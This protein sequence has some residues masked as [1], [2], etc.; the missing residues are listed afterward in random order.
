MSLNFVNK[1][2]KEFPQL[3]HQQPISAD[4]RSTVRLFNQPLW[5]TLGGDR[6]D[7]VTVAQRIDGELEWPEI[8]PLAQ[9]YAG[10][11]FGHFNPYLGDG[12]GLLLG[13]VRA[14]SGNYYDLHLKGAGP[15]PY[16]RGGDGRAVLRS[17]IREY[18]ASEAFAALGIPTTRA[19]MLTST[20]GEIQRER[21]EPGAMLLRVARTHVRFGHFEHCYYRKLPKQ[22]MKLWQYVIERAW[23]DVVDAD[24][25]QQ[26]RRVMESTAVMIALWQ[27]YGFIHGVMNTDN[28]S[29]LG[30]TFDYG[31]Y[32]MLDSYQPEK[33]F[34]HTDQGGR[35]G[36][37][38]QPG[39]GRWNLQRLQVAL[40]ASMDVEPLTEV[41]DDYEGFIQNCYFE[42]MRKRLGLTRVE[43][44]QARQLIVGWLELLA[45]QQ[46]D[47]HRSFI[48][49][50]Q[51]IQDAPAHDTALG[52]VGDAWLQHY[53]AVVKAPDIATM[54]AV[55]PVVTLRTHL[56]NEVIEH[57]ERGND[58]PLVDYLEALEHP[59]E[60][61]RCSSHWAQ[62]PVVEVTAGSLSCSS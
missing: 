15:T 7:P 57:A 18:L 61:S 26:F 59:L 60:R 29:L 46:L 3:V 35:Y 50:E 23:P 51:I 4:G 20:E 37:M 40:S 25:A 52:K 44:S 43:P 22:Q 8:E 16:G 24:H 45:R 28:M 38:Q 13:E 27:A 36:F 30:E 58:H 42:Q 17:S 5:Q 49:L 53:F 62:P 33:I 48:E 31:P 14:P 32:A 56:L 12:R 21:V 9:K 1:F 34:N 6:V 55:N 10:H 41:L 47:Y 2:G 39:I 11:Q 54:H 19:L